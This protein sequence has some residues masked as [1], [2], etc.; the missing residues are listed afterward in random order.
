MEIKKCWILLGIPIFLGL[1]CKNNPLKEFERIE[2]TFATDNTVQAKFRVLNEACYAPCDL[3]FINESVNADTYQWNI[4]LGDTVINST[5]FE[6]L[7]TFGAGGNF[8]VQLIA[9]NEVASDDTTVFVAIN[10]VQTGAFSFDLGGRSCGWDVFQLRDSSYIINTKYTNKKLIKLN[11]DLVKTAEYQHVGEA[12]YDYLWGRAAL[13]STDEIIIGG[14]KRKGDFSSQDLQSHAFLLKLTGALSPIGEEVPI[15]NANT[16]YDRIASVVQTNS[17]G[18]VFTGYYTKHAL[19]YGEE[20]TF[21]GSANADLNLL[22]IR[23]E[24]EDSNPGFT[25]RLALTSSNNVLYL[26]TDFTTDVSKII[27]L[28]SFPAFI[29]E[30]ELPGFVVSNGPVESA[31]GNYAVIG[32]RENTARTSIM[33]INP[34][35]GT[36]AK[37]EEITDKVVVIYC[38]SPLKNGGYILAGTQVTDTPNGGWDLYLA[39]VD[40]NLKLDWEKSFGGALNDQGWDARETLDGGF[41][42]VGESKSNGNPNGDLFVVKT[43]YRGEIF[44]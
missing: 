14:G 22:N 30:Y 32:L 26:F 4:D 16:Q 1:A 9:R 3:T 12:D 17:G 37:E 20:S 44:E 10:Q 42:A 40:E 41:I 18:I 34:A 19:D 38:I 2:S 23:E 29:E 13:L 35:L 5:D 25:T 21:F 15:D 6:P 8:S 11:S 31:G 27:K 36:I 39:R 7:V 33:E 24:F 28:T 43:D